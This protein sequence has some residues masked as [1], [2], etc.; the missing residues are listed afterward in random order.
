MILKDIINNKIFINKHILNL[1]L[2]EI[3]NLTK[4]EIF[5]KWNRKITEKEFLKIKNM[6]DQYEKENIPIE[7]IL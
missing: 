5:T 2:Q 3:L 7:Y 6:Y 1:I 4:E